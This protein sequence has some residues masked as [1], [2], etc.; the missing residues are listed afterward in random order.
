MT[1]HGDKSF[2]NQIFYIFIN[3]R[4]ALFKVST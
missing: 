2:L 3:S 4:E 1:V